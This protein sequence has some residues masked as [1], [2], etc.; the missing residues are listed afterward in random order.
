[1]LISL[2]LAYFLLHG[3]AAAGF[4]PQLE[5]T[6]ERIKEHVTVEATQKQAL[7]V[8]DTATRANKAFLDQQKRDVDALSKVLAERGASAEQI[9]VAIAPLLAS[10]STVAVKLVNARFQLRALLTAD[11][12]SKVF[13]KA[14]PAGTK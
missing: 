7:A 6:G 2:V 9:D 4:A 1:M 13:P 11:E 10:D 12:W 14:A 5:S 8:I 3:S